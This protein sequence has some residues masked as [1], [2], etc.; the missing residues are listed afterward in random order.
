MAISPVSK[1]SPAAFPKEARLRSPKEFE[2]AMGGERRS[3]GDF[4]ARALWN[5]S[6]PRLGLIVG[7][8]FEPLSPRRNAIKR[9]A[10][11]AFRELA[12]SLPPVDIAL[13]LAK[14][15]KPQE[16][17]AEFK[18]RVRQEIRGLLALC[19]TL[20]PPKA[21]EGSAAAPARR[22]RPGGRA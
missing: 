16:S 4:S 19:A 6:A 2:A 14:K 18:A 11:E 20:T 3:C 8:R 1:A 21:A 22:K 7:A 17:L 5:G 10:R 13:R 15:G 9:A 12:E